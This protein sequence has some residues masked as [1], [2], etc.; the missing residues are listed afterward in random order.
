MIFDINLIFDENNAFCFTKKINIHV[1]VYNLIFT[2]IES[3]T[4]RVFQHHF[5]LW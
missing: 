5:I 1:T 2:T 3:I 4:P